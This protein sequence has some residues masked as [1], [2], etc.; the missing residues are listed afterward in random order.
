M[1]EATL[2]FA[3]NRR[4]KG[5]DRWNPGGYTG[6]PSGDGAE[7]LRFGRV[8]LPCDADKVGKFLAGDCGFGVG[9]GEDL[10]AY[11]YKQRK[12]ASITAFEE[13]LTKFESDTRQD[14]K[15]FGSTRTFTELQKHMLRTGPPDGTRGGPGGGHRGLQRRL[16]GGGKLGAEP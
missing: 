14:Q 4:H 7:N 11:L 10:A 2:Y 6:E 8:S 15:L 1:T 16:L 9:N 5:R 12:K 13:K 3:T